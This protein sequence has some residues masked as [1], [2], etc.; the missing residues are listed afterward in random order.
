MMRIRPL[1]DGEM[2]ADYADCESAH[3]SNKKCLV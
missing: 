3:L 2:K 1:W